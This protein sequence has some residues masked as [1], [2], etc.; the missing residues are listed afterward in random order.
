MT[1]EKSV[2]WLFPSDSLKKF[3]TSWQCDDSILK[4]EDYV[5]WWF[6]ETEKIEVSSMIHSARATV[7][8]VANI[9]FLL[10]FVLLWKVVTDGRTNDMC[11][12]N[13]HNQLWLWVGLVDQKVLFFQINWDRLG[14][15]C[16]AVQ[17]IFKKFL[18]K[19]QNSLLLQASLFIY[20]FHLLSTFRLQSCSP[21]YSYFFS[22][23]A[24]Q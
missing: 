1:H 10:K 9:V 23:W 15:L 11:K 7:S 24:A 5:T 22:S 19:C 16:C 17:Q 21:V 8:P 6:L 3:R 14:G 18:S 4:K 12:N 20:K 13:D 2:I